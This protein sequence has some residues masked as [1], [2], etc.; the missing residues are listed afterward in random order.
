MKKIRLIA[1]PVVL[2][3]FLVGWAVPVEL[4]AQKVEEKNVSVRGK[5]TAVD[6]KAKTITVKVET[7]AGKGGSRTVEVAHATKIQKD[8]KINQ[9]L[10]DLAV[11]DDVNMMFRQGTGPTPRAIQIIV[12][13]T[14]DQVASQ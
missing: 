8:N 5:I 13:G 2:A 6:A 9:K 14:A 1:T 11:G 4:F 10:K 12:L 7:G 3:L